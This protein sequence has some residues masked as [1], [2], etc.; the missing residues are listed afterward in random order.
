MFRGWSWQLSV[1]IAAAVGMAKAFALGLLTWSAMG[2]S[3]DAAVRKAGEGAVVPLE[4]ALSLPQSSFT[5]GMFVGMLFAT[6]GVGL[7]WVGV[8]GYRRWRR[9]GLDPGEEFAKWDF[10]I[11]ER[12]ARRG[13]RKV[14]SEERQR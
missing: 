14:G 7:G 13:R 10:G 3:L 12:L 4:V 6:S 8:S 2:E 5:T 1:G 9:S 11:L